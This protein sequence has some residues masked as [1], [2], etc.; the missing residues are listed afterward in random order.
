MSISSEFR[1]VSKCLHTCRPSTWL[2]HERDMIVVSK[3]LWQNWQP[4]D[5]V[6]IA[7]P[8]MGTS[9]LTLGFGPD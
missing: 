9:N 3:D 8:I 2:S 4:V 5:A 6:H 1:K 7:Y